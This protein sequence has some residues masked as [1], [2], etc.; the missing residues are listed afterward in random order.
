MESNI[1]KIMASIEE[2]KNTPTVVIAFKATCAKNFP[3]TAWQSHSEGPGK[4][5]SQSYERS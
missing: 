3:D 1:E 5:I 2:L 4:N